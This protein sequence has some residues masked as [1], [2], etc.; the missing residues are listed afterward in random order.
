MFSYSIFK[1]PGLIPS[2]LG[3]ELI[4]TV[5]HK[6]LS[7]TLDKLFSRSYLSGMSENLIVTNVKP[8]IGRPPKY[9]GDLIPIAIAMAKLGATDKELMAELDVNQSTINLWRHKHKAFSLACEEGKLAFDAG[10]VRGLARKAMWRMET[11]QQ[12][13][14]DKD[15]GRWH[16]LQ[17]EEEVAPDTAS[18]M[19][20]LKNRMPR[21]WRDKVELGQMVEHNHTVNLEAP[22]TRQLA[23]ALLNVMAD[24]KREHERG[25]FID[26][27]PTKTS[28]TSIADADASEVRPPAQEADADQ[29]RRQVREEQ[30]RASRGPVATDDVAGDVSAARQRRRARIMGSASD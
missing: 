21:E 13:H 9:S 2:F 29:P 26:V 7:S 30:G 28:N 22:D 6:Y 17:W 4:L 1:E 19:I 12:A 14:F 8:R 18:M 23:I 15:T 25:D 5:P 3:V 10:I 20:W 24:A 16:V 11:K 27:T